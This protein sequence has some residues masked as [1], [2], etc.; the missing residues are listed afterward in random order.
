MPMNNKK[1]TIKINIDPKYRG[2]ICIIIAAFG[3]AFMNLFVKLSGD[4]PAIEKGFFRNLVAVFVAL[5]IMIKNKIPFTTG[6]GGL[7]YL[8]LR[9]V[10]GTLGIFTNFYAIS[11]INISDASMLNKLSPFFAIL[12][13]AIMIKEKPKL[14][15]LL[16]VVVAF[17][18]AIFILKP[19]ADSVTFIPAL[20]GISGA[21]FAGFAYTNVRIA[22]MHKVP[23]PFIVFFFSLF[24][25]LSSVPYMIVNFVPMTHLQL[26][27]LLLAGV[28]ASLGQIF[29]TKAY[30]YSPASEISVYDYTQIIF[31]AILGMIFLGEFPDVISIIGY[32]IIS[33]AAITMFLIRRHKLKEE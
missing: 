10:S 31:A 29:I 27:Y 6:E 4:L 11:M 9:S 33:G 26:L 7:K 22:S 3:F 14:Y 20:I 12:F 24:S 16:C 18:G 28:S 25:C 30:S 8:I 5:F 2:I 1:K 32:I 23:G 19:G 17:I 13:S 15:Q 21:A